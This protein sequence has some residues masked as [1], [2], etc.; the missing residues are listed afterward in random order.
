VPTPVR[1]PGFDSEKVALV[2]GELH[3]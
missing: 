2:S 3:C 1:Q